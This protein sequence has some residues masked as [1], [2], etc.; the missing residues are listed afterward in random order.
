MARF[1]GRARFW[2]LLNLSGIWMHVM[3]K[4]EMG[5][6]QSLEKTRRKREDDQQ[7]TIYERDDDQQHPRGSGHD[8]TPGTRVVSHGQSPAAGPKNFLSF[9]FAT[10]VSKDCS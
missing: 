1:L 6:T 2:W 3:K 7:T 5:L 10:S 8:P 4:E 9:S